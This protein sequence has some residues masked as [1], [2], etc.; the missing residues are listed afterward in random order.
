MELKFDSFYYS[1]DNQIHFLSEIVSIDDEKLNDKYKGKM[2]CPLCKAVQL[3]LSHGAKTTFLRTYPK[4]T[5][6]FVNGSPCLYSYKEA[7][8]R[9]V[10]IYID[11]LRDKKKIKSLLNSTL[12]YLLNDKTK[13]A[14]TNNQKNATF[15]PLIIEPAKK[16][17]NKERTVIPHYSFKSW[18]VSVPDDRLVII[19][20]KVKIVVKESATG[21][22]AYLHFKTIDSDKFITS[23]LKP[24]NV[25]ITDGLYY[26]A[27]LGK[28]HEN[29]GF[30][31]IILNKPESESITI[32]AF[33]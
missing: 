13:L 5:H 30:Q 16:I 8:S 33:S 32:L 6:G 23:C 27:L 24:K 12:R 31:N 9:T 18:G 26:V 11:E 1:D 28:R 22:Y 4:Q 19:Y 7:S 2:Y 17:K 20:G 29:K 15:N 21:D 14:A 3:S 10:N 25:E